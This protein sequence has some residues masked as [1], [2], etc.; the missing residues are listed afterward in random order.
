LWALS[1]PQKGVKEKGRTIADVAPPA[2]RSTRLEAHEL[3]EQG[4]EPLPFAGVQVEFR[5]KR[6][7]RLE[8]ALLFELWPLDTTLSSAHRCVKHKRPHIS[9][10]FL[11]DRNRCR[12]H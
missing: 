9:L 1:P 2:T 3:A 8:V 6:N 7:L 5:R 12:E 10:V 4:V 11:A